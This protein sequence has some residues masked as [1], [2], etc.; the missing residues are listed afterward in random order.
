M[1]Y[2]WVWIPNPPPPPAEA[3]EPLPP[4]AP[5]SAPSSPPA[6]AEGAAPRKSQL[7]RWVDGEGVVHLTDNLENVPEP[8]RKP[9]TR[10]RPF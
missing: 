6:S 2:T 4:P 3:P 1:P 7:Y 10:T 5:R 8:Y 9:A